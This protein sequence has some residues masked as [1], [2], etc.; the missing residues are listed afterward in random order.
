[1]HDETKRDSSLL[2][3]MTGTLADHILCYPICSDSTP[4]RCDKQIQIRHYA[5]QMLRET[6]VQAN[7]NTT[8]LMNSYISSA[9]RYA[10]ESNL[11]GE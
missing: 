8:F 5:G 4:L 3:A 2:K 9:A 6:S 1:M 10:A 11:D 7:E